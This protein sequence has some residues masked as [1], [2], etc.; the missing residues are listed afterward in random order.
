VAQGQPLLH[1]APS[2][3]GEA[4]KLLVLKL[5]CLEGR[6]LGVETEAMMCTGA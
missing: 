4:S 1:R 2:A 6:L 5:L 3:S